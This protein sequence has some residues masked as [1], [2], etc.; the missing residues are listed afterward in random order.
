MPEVTFKI[1]QS[2]RTKETDPESLTFEPITMGQELEAAKVAETKGGGGLAVTYECVR[3]SVTKV[4]GKTVDWSGTGPEWMEKAGQKVLTLAV[5][6][7]K[8]VNDPDA[9]ETASFLESASAAG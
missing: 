9:S 1:P 7:Y 2:A 5:R 8:K 4:N 3:R 6:G